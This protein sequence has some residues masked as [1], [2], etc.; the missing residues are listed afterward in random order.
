MHKSIISNEKP[1]G[2]ALNKGIFSLSA[3]TFLL[4]GCANLM[5]NNAAS[6]IE[7]QG[8]TASTIAA[9]FLAPL[10]KVDAAQQAKFDTWWAQFNDATLLQLVN[11]AVAYNT[12]VA[13]ARASIVAARSVVAQNRAGLF[14]SVNATASADAT[15]QRQSGITTNTRTVRTGF[16]ALWELDL[17]GFNQ[18]LTDAADA[19]VNESIAQFGDTRVSIAAEVA[20][21][22]VNL[23]T[24]QMLEAVYAQDR[25][26]TAQ[27]ANLTN[28][29]IKAGFEAQANAGLAEGD[30]AE[31][32]NR[33]TAQR[34]QTDLYIKALVALTNKNEAT[35]RAGLLL[36]TTPT[37]LPAPKLF[38]VD[39]V[40][41]TLLTQRADVAAATANVLAAN[42][43]WRASR[44]D[45][46]PRISLMGNIG[47]NRVTLSG[48]SSNSSNFSFGPAINLPLFDAGRRQA[49]TDGA[50][51]RIDIAQATFEQTALRAV[52]ETEEGLVRLDS[53]TVRAKSAQ[54]A[55]RGYVSY[56]EGAQLR[57]KNGLA[58]LQEL[59]QAQRTTVAANAALLQ[60][61]RERVQAWIALYKALG[62]GWDVS[63]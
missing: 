1:V 2:N 42:A 62:G 61:Q 20:S 50:K 46:Y 18:S 47:L 23:R 55:V 16:D 11:H 12:S 10:P 56:L 29:K 19:R 25:T 31:A 36:A 41:A 57:H 53:A 5:P 52:Q 39:T 21:I 58:S 63:K 27:T 44:A 40:P 45:Q 59:A 24:S 13:Q 32:A 26:A 15:R 51:A 54:D 38:A 33:Y 3:V 35:L 9:K 8:A 7:P 49:A 43:D 14:P 30:A 60:V 6:T 34:E 17:F 4:S 48:N 37:A 28:L 22:Y